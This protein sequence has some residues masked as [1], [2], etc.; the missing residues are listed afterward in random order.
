MS[1]TPIGAYC[2]CTEGQSSAAQTQKGHE[3]TA[4]QTAVHTWLQSVCV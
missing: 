1:L 2:V 3:Q 4:L